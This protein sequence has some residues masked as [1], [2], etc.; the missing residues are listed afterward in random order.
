MLSA[1]LFDYNVRFF[2]SRKGG[3]IPS[4]S[5][6][7]ESFIADLLAQAAASEEK[8]SVCT[9]ID[10]LHSIAQT[11]R[12][13]VRN[14]ELAF[15][16]YRQVDSLLERTS[17]SVYP[18]KAYYRLDIAHFYMTFGDYEHAVIYFRKILEE[19][20]GP[21]NH[22]YYPSIL[23]TY[24][25]LGVC[26]GKGYED[27]EQSDFYYEEILRFLRRNNE[28]DNHIWA[29]IAKGNLGYNRYLLKDY[30][31]ALPMLLFSA[32]LMAENGD[33]GYAAGQT[34]SLA[35]IY[36]LQNNMT[37]AKRYIAL[38][39]RYIS[40][41]GRNDRKKELF[42]VMGKYYALQGDAVRAVAYMDS[43]LTARS[44]YEEE[45][46][47][48]KLLR[49]EQRAHLLESRLQ[50]ERLEGE[51]MRNAQYRRYLVTLSASLLVAL[52]LIGIILFMYRRIRSNY[53]ELVL[54]SRQRAEAVDSL[55]PAELGEA[56]ADDE[57]PSSEAVGAGADAAD[58][59]VMEE[60][61]LLMKQQHAYRNPDLSLDMLASQS[62]LSRYAIS[63]A[64]NRCTGKNY[65]TYIN[66]YRI[67]DA[68]RIMSAKDSANLSIEG[69]AFDSGFNDRRIFH[70]VF[71]QMTGL[72]PAAFKR[73]L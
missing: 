22:F 8:N 48:T 56:S 3:L 14:Y 59:A 63:R 18:P 21:D 37:E 61:E 57:P 17:I 40:L 55:Q 4:D 25:S 24:N 46:G 15:K 50:Q 12:I 26:F 73:N 16:Y 60:I 72:T 20:P 65:Y 7:A 53:R 5:Y 28:P 54:K 38:S 43:S 49:L 45:F 67:K 41:S 30:D 11:Y 68:I 71:K 36:T 34:I 27:Y 33:Y 10:A 19:L 47:A 2:N 35:D 42:V 23:H 13:Y 1:Q 32:S 62:G 44:E 64:I 9:Q 6:T 70:R 31:R 51:T 29:G 52:F 39:E 69:I 58:L 66:E